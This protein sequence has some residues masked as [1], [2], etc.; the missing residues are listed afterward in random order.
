M[1][2]VD[3]DGQEDLVVYPSPSSTSENAPLVG[4]TWL[5][6]MAAMPTRIDEA[7]ELPDMHPHYNFTTKRFGDIDGDGHADLILYTFSTGGICPTSVYLLSGDGQG[8]FTLSTNVPFGAPPGRVA[9]VPTPANWG[10]L[11][12]VDGDGLLDLVLGPDDDGDPGQLWLLRGTGR[13]FDQPEEVLD[14]IP[15][16]ENGQDGGGNG[17]VVLDD[18]N[19]DGHLDAAVFHDPNRRLQGGMSMRIQIHL[20]DGTGAF[21]T[22]AWATVP[23]PARAEMV[24]RAR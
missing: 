24:P 9:V 8:H 4:Y 15:A 10:D 6:A 12:D 11:G 23:V 2:D 3:G 5:N 22:P 13:G 18:W 7:F 20:G 17:M 19:N 14:V 21:V 1:G 16:I